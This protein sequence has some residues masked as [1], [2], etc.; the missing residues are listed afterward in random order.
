MKGGLKRAEKG[1]RNFLAAPYRREAGGYMV[2]LG[3]ISKSFVD[4]GCTVG[5]STILYRIGA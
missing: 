5:Y 4:G 3:A 2:M 1:L